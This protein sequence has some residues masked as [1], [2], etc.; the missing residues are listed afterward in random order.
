VWSSISAAREPVTPRIQHRC[1]K[2]RPLEG[3]ECAG[4]SMRAAGNP[5]AE[6]HAASAGGDSRVGRSAQP[7]VRNLS[8]SLNR[9]RVL[10]NTKS[11]DPVK[12]IFNP[13]E[14]RSKPGAVG[15]TAGT[16]GIHGHVLS[17]NNKSYPGEAEE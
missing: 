7:T 6:R 3:L 4:A 14:T 1:G 12:K 9:R 16:P 13:C 5:K 17:P 8:A 11:A 10:R 2:A 15:D